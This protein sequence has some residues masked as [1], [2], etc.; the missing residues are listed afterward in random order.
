MAD[1][2]SNNEN[3]V[4]ETNLQNKENEENINLA[5]FTALVK[6]D[7]E[8]DSSD[9][10]YELADECRSCYGIKIDH[11][12]IDKM[13][14]SLEPLYETCH[15]Q[16]WD[17]WT[18]DDIYLYKGQWLVRYI[19]K[20]DYDKRSAKDVLEKEVK[21]RHIN[22]INEIITRYDELETVVKVYQG[23]YSDKWKENLI[24]RVDNLHTER[25]Y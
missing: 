2:L 23:V 4:A 13:V 18:Q 25:S 8:L 1:D 11:I 19:R 12:Y 20:I 24:K 22:L 7:R 16:V 15:D 10:V 21:I 14:S 5:N 9:Q 17:S 6:H 3:L